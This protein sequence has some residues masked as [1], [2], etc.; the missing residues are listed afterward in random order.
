MK[1]QSSHF[2]SLVLIIALL[3]VLTVTVMM[4]GAHLGLWEPIVGFGYIRN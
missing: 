1:R 4:F 3:A 2:G